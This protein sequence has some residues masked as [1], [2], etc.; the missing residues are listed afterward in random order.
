TPRS[1]DRPAR[2]G[3]VLILYAKGLGPTSPTVNPGNLFPREPLAVVTS[4]VEVLVNGKPSPPI[5]QVG[6][7]GT[8]DVY[9]VAFRVPD[10]TAA[11]PA[12]VQIRAAW[13]PGPRHYRT[14]GLQRLGV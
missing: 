10:D 9:H 1:S 13:V 2:P 5:N 8:S 6:L 14:L 12:S 11:G 3:E 7:P 4:P